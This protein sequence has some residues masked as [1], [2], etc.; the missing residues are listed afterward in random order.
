MKRA[1]TIGLGIPVALVVVAQFYPVDRSNPEVT[2]DLEAPAEVKMI[3]RTA[4]YDCHSNETRWPWYSRVAPVSW[5]VAGDVHAA[6]GEF[7]LSA[8]GM[9]PPRERQSLRASMWRH[10]DKGEMPL[11]IYLL[12]HSEA[13]LSPES[14]QR[15]KEWALADGR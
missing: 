4:C 5:L 6:R 11:P 13:R 14:R 8:W 7:N 12:L 9:M 2:A 3:L 15:L 10:V 1:W